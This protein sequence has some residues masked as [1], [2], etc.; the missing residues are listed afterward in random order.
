MITIINNDYY[1]TDLQQLYKKGNLVPFIGA[2]CSVPFNVP[3]WDTLILEYAETINVQEFPGFID[4]VKLELSK[5]E[6]WEAVRA[7]KRYGKRS[8]QDIQEYVCKSV[9]KK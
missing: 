4:L 5:F 2:G 3:D 1:I 7:I 8:E 6:Y 9:E